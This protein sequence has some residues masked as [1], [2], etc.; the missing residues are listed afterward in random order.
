MTDDP[1]VEEARK[2]GQAYIDS[3]NGDLDALFADLQRRTEEARRAG[4]EVA[5]LPPRPA[6]PRPEG[7]KQPG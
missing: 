7:V 4:R 6:Q 2:A 1:L 5:S 3:F